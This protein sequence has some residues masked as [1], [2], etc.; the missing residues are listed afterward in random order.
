MEL[1]RSSTINPASGRETYIRGALLIMFV[2]KFQFQK[3]KIKTG[4]DGKNYGKR[5]FCKIYSVSWL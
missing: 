2:Q 3:I 5:V 1:F 4:K